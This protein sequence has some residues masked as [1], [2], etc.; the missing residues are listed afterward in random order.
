MHNALGG[1]AVAKAAQLALARSDS[2]AYG[3]LDGRLAVV[4]RG[5]SVN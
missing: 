4:P 1:L 2:N 5:K 3:V